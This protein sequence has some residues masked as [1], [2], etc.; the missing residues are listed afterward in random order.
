MVNIRREKILGRSW[1]YRKRV[2]LKRWGITKSKCFRGI[3][4]GRY[5]LYMSI[6]EPEKRVNISI[7]DK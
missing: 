4:A 1:I 3:H 6:S 7:T 5:S 2:A